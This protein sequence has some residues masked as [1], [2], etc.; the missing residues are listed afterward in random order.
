[1]IEAGIFDGDLL[2]VDRAVRASNGK[3][4]I[5][6]LDG[7]FLIKRFARRGMKTF[8]IPENPA[9][10]EID[11]TEREDAAVWGVVTYAIHKL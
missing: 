6:S 9:Y 2:V 1:M 4:V 11:I 8:L 5:A 7:D 10:Q 3:I